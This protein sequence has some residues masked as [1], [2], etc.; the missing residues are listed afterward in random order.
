MAKFY[1]EIDSD[2][3]GRIASKG[4]DE[5]ITV[6]FTNGNIRVFEV[7]FKDDGARRGTL[8]V[9]N[10]RDASTRILEY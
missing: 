1:A 5:Y 6:A 8:E 3:R 9:L 2:K 7:T 4:G 10:F